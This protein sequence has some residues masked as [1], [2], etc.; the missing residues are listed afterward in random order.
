MPRSVPG[1]CRRAVA[2]CSRLANFD[3]RAAG[4]CEVANCYQTTGSGAMQDKFAQALDTSDCTAAWLA[5]C[6]AFQSWGWRD[7]TAKGPKLHRWTD[8]L[9]STAPAVPP[10][11]MQT[12]ASTTIRL[13][14]RKMLTDAVPKRSGSL[15]NA[16]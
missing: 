3:M 12:L 8:K 16:A 2:S 11:H 1:C 15:N 13:T 6:N 10:Y 4:L 14:V 5:T 7:P 9:C